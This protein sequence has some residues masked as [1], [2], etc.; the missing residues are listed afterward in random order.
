MHRRRGRD[1]VGV[2]AGLTGL[3]AGAAVARRGVGPIEQRVFRAVNR[4][5]DRASPAIWV[6]MQYGTFGAVPALSALSLA[7]RRP[8]V[9]VSPLPPG[10]PARVP[11][12]AGETGGA[13]GRPAGD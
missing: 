11:A 2:F 7:R 13:P 6:P 5:P 12:E 1:V 9:A 3:V 10:A 4:L 8:P